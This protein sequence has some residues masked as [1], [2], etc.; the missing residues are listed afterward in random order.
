MTLYDKA[1]TEMVVRLI[2][3]VWDS[4]AS[5]AASLALPTV[6]EHLFERVEIRT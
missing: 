1:G 3:E 5:H 4:E 6:Y 2:T